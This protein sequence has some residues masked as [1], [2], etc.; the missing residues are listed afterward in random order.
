M[1]DSKTTSE[2]IVSAAINLHQAGKDSFAIQILADAIQDD[3]SF[4]PAHVLLG[5]LHQAAGNFQE[6]EASYHSALKLDPINSEALQGLGLFLVSQKRYTEAV[7]YLRA[8]LEK[9]PADEKSINAIEEA[10]HNLPGREREIEPVLQNAWHQSKDVKLG[11]RLARYFGNHDEFQSA[12]NILTSV[13]SISKTA[14]TLSEVA[15]VC[16]ILNALDDAIT[17]AKEA[18]SLDPTCERAWRYLSQAYYRQEKFQEALK[19]IEKAIDLDPTQPRGWLDKLMILFSLGRNEEILNILDKNTK[20]FENA[21]P[22]TIKVTSIMHVAA[23]ANLKR[24][25]EALAESD[26]VRIKYGEDSPLLDLSLSILESQEKYAEILS[27]IDS[28]KKLSG[29]KNKRLIFLKLTAQ[30]YTGKLASTNELVDFILS[31]PAKN[32]MEQLRQLGVSLYRKGKKVEAQHL[33][34]QVIQFR[35]EDWPVMTNLGFM[36]IGDKQYSEAEQLL[37]QVI[38]ASPEE[39]HGSIAFCDLAYL[40]SLSG[41]FEKAVLFA[42]KALLSAHKSEMAYLRVPV[43]KSG[44]LSPDIKTIPDDSMKIEDNARA[45]MALATWASGQHAKALQI[46]QSITDHLLRQSLIDSLEQAESDT[47]QM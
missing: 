8:H 16:I 39:V 20:L 41:E 21:D 26:R 44:I 15:L 3:P 5:A 19:A 35:P 13:V 47:P 14:Q 7:P 38:D 40:Y 43:W 30:L 29:K 4:V 37:Q 2:L 34:R 6:S 10:L 25:D 17:S 12:R 45:C 36:L 33:Y 24:Y 31:Q 22:A 18:I 23:L 11:I 9:T 42:E 28:S 46:L 32:D 1:A 27:L